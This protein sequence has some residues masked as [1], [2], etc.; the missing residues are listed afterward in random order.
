MASFQKNFVVKNGLEVGLNGG[1]ILVATSDG[2]GIG[3]TLP[4]S[5]L[6]VGGNAKIAG[7]TTFGNNVIIDGNLTVSGTETIVNSSKLEVEDIN[8]G[9]ASATNK[10][11]DIQLDGAG[12]TIYGSEGDKTLTWDSSN[13][14]LAFS[15]DAY[16]PR[17]NADTFIGNLEGNLNGLVT[18]VDQPNITSLGDLTGLSV[19]GI[20]TL[21]N[22]VEMRSD[23]GTP[24]KIDFYCEVNNLH[25]TRLQSAPHSQYSG[26][27][28][29]TL[30]VAS[31]NLIV[32]DTGS[33]ISNDINTTGSIEASSFV[34]DGRG[35]TGL[36]AGI[37]I[38]TSSGPVS[39]G[40]TTL[41][42][43]GSGISTSHIDS[44]SGIATIFL[45]GGSGSGSIN[46][47]LNPPSNPEA[48][49]LWYSPNHARTFIYYDESQV[50]YGS[51]AY[52]VDSSPFQ[53]GAMDIG[54]ENLSVTGLITGSEMVLSGIAT[55]SEFD[56]TGLITGSGMVLSGIATA[57]EF[58][59]LSDINYKK[60]IKTVE[61]G[62]DKIVSL[63]GVSYDWKQ[64]D[65]P[66]YGVIAQELEEVLPELVHGGSGNDPKTVNYNG[67]IGVMI[68]SIK[69][70]KQEVETLKKLI[71]N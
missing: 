1:S 3:S 2:V 29:V 45:E 48:G 58:D 15:T 4:K 36:V 49:D 12:I 47:S 33:P 67:I 20:S 68:E 56:V 26:I 52:W 57:S 55:A 18:R 61:N 37:G 30:P 32:G 70:L 53:I 34:G 11:T 66:S 6:D 31:G 19:S 44:V 38:A 43:K 23:D 64:S 10:L 7:I 69:E 54:A 51:N 16:A 24:A 39:Y 28:I 27:P 21:E 60:N 40:I 59:A 42:L 5:T 63:R 22:K 62:L 65:R 35:L 13:S 17:L 41:E 50:G 9:I 46:I 71:N 14:R 25:Y 8:I